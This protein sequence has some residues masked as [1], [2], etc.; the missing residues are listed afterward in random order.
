MLKI[1][2]TGGIGTG[3]STVAKIFAA[4]K[5]P[6][7]EADY[8]AKVLIENDT[9]IIEKIKGLLGE[10]SYFENGKYNKSFVAQKVFDNPDL[11]K[12]LNGIV[13]PAVGKDFTDWA[14]NQRNTPYIIKE[15]AVMGKNSGLDKIIVVSSPLELRISRIQKRDKRS[16]E[17]IEIIIKNQK[18]EEQF[19][20][21]SDFEIKNNEQDFIITQ[22]LKIDKILRK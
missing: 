1:G 4:L 13:H 12:K 14:N 11:L 7:Y 18:S 15:A 17:E 20:E 21:I 16:V 2:I 19:L 5:I 3:K 8:R 10:E 6:V 22:V 9:S